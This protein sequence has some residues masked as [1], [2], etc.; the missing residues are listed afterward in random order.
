MVRMD[1]VIRCWHSGQW[2]FNSHVWYT[3]HSLWTHYDGLVD[4][5]QYPITEALPIG[6]PGPAPCHTNQKYAP[7][8]RRLETDLQKQVINF[9]AHMITRVGEPLKAHVIIKWAAQ[10]LQESL[11]HC[12]FPQQWFENPPIYFTQFIGLC[13]QLDIIFGSISPNSWYYP[14]FSALC[15]V[16]SV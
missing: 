4:G 12:R 2:Q 7:L 6:K 10:N 14:I 3:V 5:Q 11:W 15:W 8:T 9:S 1:S 13:W 16:I